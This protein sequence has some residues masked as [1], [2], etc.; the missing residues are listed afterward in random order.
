M[1]L[2]L[3]IVIAAI[4]ILTALV[5]TYLEMTDRLKSA[6][7]VF[8]IGVALAVIFALKFREP[9][10]PCTPCDCHCEYIVIKECE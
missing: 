2:L 3:K 6:I 5:C 9:E 8:I 1:T 4:I 10:E 7:A